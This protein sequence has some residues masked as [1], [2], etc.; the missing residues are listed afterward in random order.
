[1]GAF[2]SDPVLNRLLTAPEHDLHI[3]RIMDEGRVLLVNWPIDGSART[4]PR[5]WAACL[6]PRYA[7]FSRAELPANARRDFYVYVDE[8][9]NFTTLAVANMF[10]E[11]GPALTI[12]VPIA[13]P[14][15]PIA[16]RT[17]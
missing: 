1:V 3:R 6:S 10:A 17:S 7:A 12:A 9:Q 13:L 15:T 11:L 2:L 5:F 4:V 14:L 8:F 16:G